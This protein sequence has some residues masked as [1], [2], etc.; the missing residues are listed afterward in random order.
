MSSDRFIIVVR[1]V[2]V[3]KKTLRPREIPQFSKR[4]P[5]RVN[6]LEK[7]HR[8]PSSGFDQLGCLSQARVDAVESGERLRAAVFLYRY[9]GLVVQPLRREVRE[10]LGGNKRQI[11]SNDDGPLTRASCQRS[12]NT[13]QRALFWINVC[14]AGQGRFI[15]VSSDNRDRIGDLEQC[16]GDTLGESLLLEAQFRLISAHPARGATGKD[17]RLETGLHD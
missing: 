11:A 9:Y 8:P 16:F 4:N 6:R 15:R 13:T 12:V 1:R 2:D 3:N 7:V 5:A 10:E 14:N 17:K